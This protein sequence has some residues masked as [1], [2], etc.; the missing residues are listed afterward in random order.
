MMIILVITKKNDEHDGAAYG[1]DM[2]DCNE[3]RC[4]TA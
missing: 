3:G 2:V 1:D 4:G